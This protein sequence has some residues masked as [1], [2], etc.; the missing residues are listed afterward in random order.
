MKRRDRTDE[1]LYRSMIEELTPGAEEYDRL[2]ASGEAPSQRQAGARRRQRRRWA[3]AL[4]VAATIVGIVFLIGH[5]DT[6]APSS[7]AS[8]ES[9]AAKSTSDAASTDADM[10]EQELLQMIVEDVA[11]RMIEQENNTITYVL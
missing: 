3:E 4:A 6:R 8:T 5:L 7:L 9:S 10:M 2:M 1:F 11:M